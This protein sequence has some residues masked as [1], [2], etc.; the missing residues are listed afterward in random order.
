MGGETTGQLS[1]RAV[2]G[3]GM[4]LGAAGII[5]SQARAAAQTVPPASFPAARVGATFDL[6]PFPPGT[7][8]P[9][10]VDIWNRTTG[11][12]MRCWKVYYQLG[13]FPASIDARIQT[14]INR[15]IQALISFKPAIKHSSAERD[16]L[17]KAVRMFH[18]AGLT[19]EVC[20]WQEVGPK[21]MTAAQYH[22]YVQYYGPA[23]RAYYPLVFDAPGYQGPKEW[24]SYDPGHALVD[25]Y[26]VDFYCGDYVNKKYTLEPLAALAGR[27]PVGIWEIG[28]TASSKFMP[29]AAEITAYLGYIT[30]FLS[31]RA[32]SG[33]PVGS[34]AWYNGPA[35]PKQN[36]QNEIAG[37]HPN[38]EAP[39]DI[40]GYRKLYKAV[41][42]VP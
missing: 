3:G 1:R 6:F 26:A 15:G 2:L 29:T 40:A 4:V 24:A 8:Y 18:R 34:V 17:A 37:T 16:K 5:R 14:M 11:T 9:Q 7:T 38:T 10:A 28:N 20:L 41:N 39:T 33:L 13:E 25:G 35:G 30:S 19:A 36:G 22:S 32:A 31:H 27:L 23:I 12:K 21:D 42:K